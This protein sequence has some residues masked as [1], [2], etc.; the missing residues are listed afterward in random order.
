MGKA[1]RKR[2]LLMWASLAGLLVTLA[3]AAFSEFRAV[4]YR[5]HTGSAPS[6]FVL[7]HSGVTVVYRVGGDDLDWMGRDV[8]VPGWSVVPLPEP[9]VWG[10]FWVP[11]CTRSVGSMTMW[12]AQLPLW[13][14]A[15]LFGIGAW[16]G[17]R[18]GWAGKDICAACG[19]DVAGLQ[20]G[21]C[22]ECGRSRLRAVEGRAS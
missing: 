22:P 11:S 9:R 17:K 15:V 16:W 7:H 1:R 12:H 10:R 14:P 4:S 21:A 19:Y 6:R 8:F 13:I 3:A 20:G 18:G 5:E 2:R